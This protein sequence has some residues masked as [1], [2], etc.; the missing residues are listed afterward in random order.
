M[1]MAT[2][3]F[4]EKPLYSITDDRLPDPCADRNPEPVFFLVVS[5]ADD[6]EMRGMKLSPSPR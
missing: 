4:S 5:F 2:K 1:V 6:N 3:K